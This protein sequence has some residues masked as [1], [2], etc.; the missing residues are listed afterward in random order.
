MSRILSDSLLEQANQKSNLSIRQANH[1]QE[2]QEMFSLL[3]KLH[4]IQGEY[5]R[6]MAKIQAEINQLDRGGM[7]F[8]TPEQVQKKYYLQNLMSQRQA[9]HGKEQQFLKNL[10]NYR[11]QYILNEKLMNTKGISN[12]EMYKKREEIMKMKLQYEQLQTEKAK[13][14]REQQNPNTLSSVGL[15]VLMDVS[16]NQ[17]FDA[18]KQKLNKDEARLQFLKARQADDILHRDLDEVM[19]SGPGDNTSNEVRYL[20][21]QSI[22]KTQREQLEHL[23]KIRQQLEEYNRGNTR[24]VLPF[25]QINDNKKI[26]NDQDSYLN[27]IDQLRK[28]YVKA[29]GVDPNFLLN[30][31]QLERSI[32]RKAN[33]SQYDVST[34]PQYIHIPQNQRNTVYQQPMAPN[35]SYSQPNLHRPQQ[36]FHQQDSLINTNSL[37]THP[38]YQYL[39]QS[40][41]EELNKLQLQTQ[42]MKLEEKKKIDPNNADDMTLE[43]LRN[44]E[45]ELLLMMNRLDPRSVDHQRLMDNYKELQKLRNLIEKAIFDKR[46][47]EAINKDKEYRKKLI[48]QQVNLF[49]RSNRAVHYA[50]SEGFVLFFDYASM[51]EIQFHTLRIN[52]GI[53]RKGSDMYPY[54]QTKDSLTA[55]ET[56]RTNKA[57]FFDRDVIRDLE[58]YPDT[59][60]FVELWGYQSNI[61]EVI[62]WSMIRL[63]QDEGKLLIGRFR[64]PFY[65]QKLNPNFLFTQA[66][67]YVNNT[68]V[69]GRICLPGDPILDSNDIIVIESEYDMPDMHIHTTAHAASL[70]EIQDVYLNEAKRF[71]KKKDIP[72]VDLGLSNQTF[73]QNISQLSYTNQSADSPVTKSGGATSKMKNRFSNRGSKNQSKNTTP[74]PGSQTNRQKSQFG[75]AK[76]T[77]R[78]VKLAKLPTNE[79][80]TA[81]IKLKLGVFNGSKILEDFEQQPQMA[82]LQLEPIKT[83]GEK[84]IEFK[85]KHE[86][87]LS[88]DWL[89]NY[90][91]DD[92]MLFMGLFINQKDLFGWLATPLFYLDNAQNDY[93]MKLGAYQ[94]NLLA[95]PGQSPP[96]NPETMKKQEIEVDFIIMTTEQKANQLP[97]YDTY[98]SLSNQSKLDQSKMS[99]LNKSSRSQGP[100]PSIFNKSQDKSGDQSYAQK[101]VILLEMLN[102]VIRDDEYIVDVAICCKDKIVYDVNDEPCKYK[103]DQ[104]FESQKGAILFEDEK[105][106]FEI[107]FNSEKN[108]GITKQAC[109]L[110]LYFS[111]KKDKV[112]WFVH[113]LIKYGRYSLPTLN[114]PFQKPPIDKTKLQNHALMTLAFDL[115]PIQ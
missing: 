100:I 27:E 106:E 41:R 19:N 64:I 6:D 89:Y 12:Q 36:G 91:G 51:V 58:A 54:K 15:S 68:L 65:S 1:D 90:R 66:L 31:T 81:P 85:T 33:G 82:V 47:S 20:L 35:I 95:P 71:E 112:T 7:K 87:T 98:V 67:P 5:E 74:T 24:L 96:F 11:E 18:A 79:Y 70:A 56:Y 99:N 86:F 55:F 88:L 43:Y 111:T 32:N 26:V 38:I 104:T 61:P 3:N 69:Y 50:A 42:P 108:Q 115:K 28:D 37:S 46:V 17:N 40:F 48:K 25:E 72:P 30:L 77:F 75:D 22:G 93:K 52:Y 60:V 59:Y 4:I 76:L 107:D 23:S 109:Q 110:L 39:P 114:L 105:I 9:T 73:K 16:K 57:V 63:F 10:Q 45:A 13:I 92:V 49:D 2:A 83:N 94:C 101:V 78:L 102:G 62:G 44:Q 29:G 84:E 14:Y 113:D 21:K 53:F 97:L 8:L 34:Q 80:K 103:I